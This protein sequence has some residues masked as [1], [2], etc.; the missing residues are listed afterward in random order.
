MFVF[1]TMANLDFVFRPY[2]GENT[3]GVHVMVV[4]TSDG[5][6]HLSMYDS[7]V[8]GSFNPLRTAARPHPLPLDLQLCGHGAHP[9]ISTHSLVFRSK[10]Q[11]KSLYFL[12]MD[13]TFVYDSPVDLALL[14]SKT[15]TLQNLLRYLK[16]ALSH[17]TGE[18]KS[19][20]ELP[21]RF[22]F[23]VREDLEKMP[24]GPMTIVQALFH[25]VT[26]GHVFP[27]VK[28]WLVDSVAER[29]SLRNSYQFRAKKLMSLS[30]AQTLAQSCG[31]WPRKS[32]QP[33]P[34]KFHPGTGKVRHNTQ[35]LA[36]TGSLS[37]QPREHRI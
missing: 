35:P 33:C 9:D 32:S 22:L 31:L 37:R 24:T 8:I 23:G 26:T 16:Q 11:G 36:W 4:G 19:T 15:T 27:P 10:E 20:R 2:K 14:A 6:I 13:L 7:F 1:T 34:S 3:E 12:P 28:D 5:G 25:T 30:G 21:A 17:M 29:V 18:W